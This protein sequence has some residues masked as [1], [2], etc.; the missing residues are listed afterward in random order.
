MTQKLTNNMLNSLASSKLTGTLPALDGSSLTGFSATTKSASDPT[1]S[2]NPSGG[3][4]TVWANTT[5]GSVFICTDATAG[6]NVW[7][8]IGSGTGDVEPF[9]GA[10]SISGYTS[11]H[12]NT[13]F[14]TI[15]KYSFTSD[16]NA[17]DHG[18]LPGHKGYCAG[19]SSSTHGY[20][21]AGHPT[22]NVIDKYQFSA[23]ANAT[24]V[25]D[26]TVAQQSLGASSST[27][28]GYKADGGNSG[29]ASNQIEKISF[30]TD[31]N[32]SDIGNL[33]NSGGNRVGTQH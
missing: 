22:T 21:S 20:T 6:S 24:D 25:G 29:S 26:L 10:G 11:G 33:T 7:K 14:N 28:H 16:G 1:L 27:T 15:E 3:V 30:S 17:T 19:N 9:H 4:G 32:A 12:A 5:S 31:G 23:S 18:D 8:N 2:T 13:P